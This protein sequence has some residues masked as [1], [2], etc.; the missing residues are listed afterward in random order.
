MTIV[1]YPRS[2]PN[3]GSKK[4][5]I[6]FNLTDSPLRNTIY[7]DPTFVPSAGHPETGHI[8]APYV[9]LQDAIEA[10]ESLAAGE[11][12][13]VLIPPGIPIDNETLTI[14]ANCNLEIAVEGESCSGSVNSTSGNLIW[15]AAEGSKLS[16]TNLTFY[17]SIA[18]TATGTAKLTLNNCNVSNAALAFTGGTVHVYANGKAFSSAISG[19]P[20]IAQISTT[21]DIIGT[22]T[23]FTAGELN[24]R[25]LILTDCRLSGVG[26]LNAS[27][28]TIDLQNTTLGAL[29]EVNFAAPGGV[30]NLDDVSGSEWFSTD[31]T[32]ANGDVNS[33]FT[34]PMFGGIVWVDANTSV[35]A[36]NRKGSAEAPFATI[37]EAHALILATTAVSNWLVNIGGI[38]YDEALAIPTGKTITYRGQGIARTVLGLA[39]SSDHTWVRT[40]NHSITFE[41][42]MLVGDTF[43][44]T[45]GAAAPTSTA[46]VVFNDAA[47][48]LGELS[49]GMTVNGV[50]EISF[51]A[52]NDPASSLGSAAGTNIPAP[53]FS[54]DCHFTTGNLYLTGVRWSGSGV[55]RAKNQYHC[56]NQFAQTCGL[57]CTTTVLEGLCSRL[58]P[59]TF[60]GSAGTANLDAYT[61]SRFD[62][63]SNIITGGSAVPRTRDSVSFESIKGEAPFFSGVAGVP[64]FFRFPIPSG[65][66]PGAAD[67]YQLNFATGFAD[68]WYIVDSWI[69]TTTAAALSSAQVRSAPGG[70]GTQYAELATAA[71]GVNRNT[72]SVMTNNVN[73]AT[74]L[75]L[76]RD[77]RSVVGTLVL[78]MMRVV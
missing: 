52:N 19:T 70:G 38:T 14:P 35:A 42:L 50:Y 32:I 77:D 31:P 10:Q 54:G 18:G 26:E 49:G 71:T 33:Y 34:I 16:L 43:T 22:Q 66:A 68:T 72:Y 6:A 30:V 2:I 39:G 63:D 58:P 53:I 41:H 78:A 9:S 36:E 65:G 7:V 5:D 44:T 73:S 46:Y 11:A 37:A 60:S 8:D 48:S 13:L 29:S 17:Q 57:V 25:N 4:R 1:R 51:I 28:G 59:I 76:R 64:V 47:F 24:F 67:D 15:N 69:A 56:A 21:G 55:I 62:S 75:Y 20:A 74:A 40:A 61:C 23:L 3:D 12:W 27:G 45:D